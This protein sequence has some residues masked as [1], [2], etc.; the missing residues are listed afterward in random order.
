M[1]P[2][3]LLETLRLRREHQQD[4]LRHRTGLIAGTD[5]GV[6]WREELMNSGYVVVADPVPAEELVV[7]VGG[8]LST[9]R[10]EAAG[11]LSTVLQLLIR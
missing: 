9:L 1:G 4:A 11:V 7:Q 10:V 5:G 2:G 3:P 6:K 8:P